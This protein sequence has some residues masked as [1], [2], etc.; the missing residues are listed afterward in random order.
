MILALCGGVGGS[1]LVRGLYRVLP[2]HELAVIVNTADD[3]ELWG[4]RVSPDIDTV[5]YTL[6]DI[7]Q[8]EAGWGIEGDSFT[9][10]EMLRRYGAPAWF[11]V[12]DRDLAT[13]VYR[14]H[15]LGAG[16]T[17]TQVT[18]HVAR[19]LG[20][21]AAILPMTD[22]P[23]AT[24]LKSGGAWLEFQ[25]YFV[26]E[27]HRLAVEAVEYAGIERA[28]PT[29]DVINAIRGAEAIL[30]VNSNPVLSIL[31]ILALP[32]VR[33]A[34]AAASA[35]T[36]AVSPLVGGRAVAGPAAELMSLIGCPPDASGVA[37]AYDGVIDGLVID[38][39]DAG[40]GGA[41][42]QRG[43]Q[44]LTANTIMRDEADRERLARETLGFARSLR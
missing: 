38:Q 41:I 44:V 5:T 1:K 7:A 9:A 21:Q 8:R 10:L 11:Q 15:A 26:R 3:L 17:L 16:K 25:E 2:Q 6:A 27:R 35:P 23:V 18:A 28:E 32:G 39:Q 37:R 40:L 12:G 33:A 36:V 34:L 30:L 20:I 14:T 43:I 24:R 13:H 42:E 4:L 31:P 19:A 29:G 22:A